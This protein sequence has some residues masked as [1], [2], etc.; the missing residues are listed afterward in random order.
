MLQIDG[1]KSNQA[2]AGDHTE[3]RASGNIGVRVV[4]VRMFGKLNDSKR[5]CNL[6][7]SLN[8]KS[9][10]I[11]KSRPMMPGE[12]RVPRPTTDLTAIGKDRVL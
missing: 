3:A 6:C 1:A 11:E 7:R 9:L 5:N 8:L 2:R 10:C 4:P 12:S